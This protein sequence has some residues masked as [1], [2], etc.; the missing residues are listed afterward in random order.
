MTMTPG[1]MFRGEGQCIFT[2]WAPLAE[3]VHVKLLS[4][5]ERTVPMQRVGRGYWTADIEDVS[6]GTQYVYVLNRTTERPD[7]ASHRQPDGV[8]GPSQVIDHDAYRW[9]DGGWRGL[10]IADYIVYELHVGAFTAGGTFNSVISELDYL[11]DLGIT[12][13]ELMPV[14]QFP[15]GRNWGYDGVYPFAVHNSYGTPDDLKRLVDECHRREMA[16]V[17]D[18]VYNHLGPEGNYLRDYGPY[19]TSKYTT[20]WGDAVNFDDEH[21]DQVRDF[22]ADNALYWFEHFHFDA[23]RLDAV[24]AIYDMGA[25]PFLQLLAERTSGFS[26]KQK[27]RY[28]LIAESDLNDARIIQKPEIGGYGID[29]QWSDDFHHSV[30]ALLTGESSGYYKD[31]GTLEHLAKA[32]REGF[33]Y[34]G[35]YSRYRNRSHGN[36]SASIPADRFIVCIQN[37]DQVGN[38]MLGERFGSLLHF[39]KLKLGAGLLILSPYIPLLFMGEEYGEDNPFLYFVSHG[40]EDLVDAVRR[41]RRAEF[42]EFHGESAAPDPQS[43]STFE[44]SKLDRS[45]AGDGRHAALLRYYKAL[46]TVRRDYPELSKPDKETA[47]VFGFESDSVLAMLRRSDR[48][49]TLIVYN[50]NAHGVTMKMKAY[51]NSWSVLLNSIDRTWGGT[52]DRAGNRIHPE[53]DLSVAGYSVLVLRN[54]DE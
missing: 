18:V 6:A 49:R 27:R 19:F 16:V 14:A 50:F 23:L 8:H 46:L 7:P 15:G 21:S 39:D 47:E 34:S 44:R 24:H 10:D 4:R 36:S 52:E 54:R 48:S 45:K 53:D 33:V 22:F 26:R 38:R 30:H 32:L 40:D 1:A 51:K 29:A 9:N 12:V 17:L 43:E 42:R 2:V 5:T 13:V 11:K 37:H 3:T 35:Q 25:K 20:P 31:F 28:Y 41:G